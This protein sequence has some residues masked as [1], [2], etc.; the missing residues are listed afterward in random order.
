M[1]N[2]EL[3][4]WLEK[5]DGKIDKI[6]EKQAEIHIQTTKTNG[7]VTVLEEKNKEKKLDIKYTIT[8]LIALSA[9]IIT[10][11]LK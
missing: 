1:E 7:R 4:G 5:L 9:L 3:V 6:S 10:I 2:C 8:T 11:F